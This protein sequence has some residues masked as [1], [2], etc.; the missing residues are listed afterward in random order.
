MIVE[1]TAGNTGIGLARAGAVFGY[2]C[3]IVIPD[4]QSPEKKAALRQ[5][6][7]HLIEVPVAPY[8]EAGNF[9]KV[10]RRLA[11][12]LRDGHG[13]RAF[14]A[15]QFDNLD[16]R[17]AHVE[18]TGPEIWRQTNGELDA[19]VKIAAEHFFQIERR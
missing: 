12:T 18:G 16:N 9:V 4:T 14:C 10:A 1:G 11:A 6:G 17:R 8:K 2:D 7:A 19:P 5:A 15:D 3:V 13:F